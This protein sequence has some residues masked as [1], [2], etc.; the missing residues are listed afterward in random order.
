[1]VSKYWKHFLRGVLRAIIYVSLWVLPM[2]AYAHDKS[3]HWIG[4][5]CIVV[6]YMV[7]V[8]LSFLEEWKLS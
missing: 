7:L 6:F 1:M 8:C 5:G 3:N 2:V 4:I